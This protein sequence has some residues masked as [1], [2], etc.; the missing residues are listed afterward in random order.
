MLLERVGLAGRIRHRPD[1]LSSGEQQRVAIARAMANSPALIL[2]DEPTGNL[3]TKNGEEI[4]GIL[5]ILNK[6]LG[7]TIVMVTHD[8]RMAR[9]ANMRL[10]LKDGRIERMEDA[11]AAPVILTAM[12]QARGDG[13]AA[14]EGMD[15]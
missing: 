1:E 4:M 2:A 5:R 12:A 13:I 8:D 10:Y 9:L 6:D 15:A 14:G 3:D 7:T 11:A